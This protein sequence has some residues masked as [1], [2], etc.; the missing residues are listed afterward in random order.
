MGSEMCIR[1]RQ[2]DVMGELAAALEDR[3][4]LSSDDIETIV[5]KQA[6]S[7]GLEQEAAE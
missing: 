3:G 4:Y 2:L 6:I 7:V 1:D 5:T